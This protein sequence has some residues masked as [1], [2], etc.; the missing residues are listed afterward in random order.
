MN[1]NLI[2]SNSDANWAADA[3]DRCST[4]GNFISLNK[5]G[6]LV[7]WKTKKHPTIALSAC[8]AT[9]PECLH[10]QQ[11]LQNIDDKKYPTKVYEDIQVAIAKA[12]NPVDGQRYK[13][14]HIKSHFV[15]SV[16]NESRISL[17][18][19]PTDDM[20]ADVLTKPATKLKL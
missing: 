14:V 13:H 7:S 19:C 15:R 17:E 20:V 1:E 12:R 18:Y 16:I 5:N 11:L 10:L 6:P 3:S 2:H 4:T 9:V 8:E